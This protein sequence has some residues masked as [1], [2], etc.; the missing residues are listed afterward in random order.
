MID[1]I[2]FMFLYTIQIDNWK[3]YSGISFEE[4]DKDFGSLFKLLVHEPYFLK[5]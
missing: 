3:M 5:S 2:E 4:A 1:N